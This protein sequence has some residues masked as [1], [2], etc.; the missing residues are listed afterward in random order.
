M[1]PSKL[2]RIDM[3]NEVTTNVWHKEAKKEEYVAVKRAKFP[4]TK[5]I[6]KL[7]TFA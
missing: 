3:K 5:K 1:K 4:T 2:A 7:D 6:T